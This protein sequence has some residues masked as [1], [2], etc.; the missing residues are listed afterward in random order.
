MKTI[1]VSLVVAGLLL[2]AIAGAQPEPDRPEKRPAA[3]DGAGPRGGGPKRPP[4]PE[5]T[6]DDREGPPGGPGG[7]E[8]GWKRAD[9]D[10]SGTLSREEFD[11]MPRIQ[12]LPVEKRDRIFAR[13]DKDGDKVLSAEELR[14][15][16]R[17]R[18]DGREAM[19][20]FR[21]LDTDHSGGVSLEEMKAGE[22]FKKLPPEK[23]AILFKRLDTDGDGEITEKDRPGP[24]MGP[25]GGERPDRP[26]RG[27][28]PPKDLRRLIRDFDEN[29]DGSLSFDEFRKAPQNKNLSEDEQEDRFEA[30]D[31][32]GD[33]KIDEQDF[34]PRPEGG[35]PAGPPPHDDGPPRDGAKPDPGPPPPAAPPAKPE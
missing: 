3:P 24:P 11:N 5:A 17:P 6:P 15:M 32:N 35:R 22:L 26:D 31:Q 10:G 29:G 21:E 20:R 8:R 27:E 13:L 34:P 4:G 2:P 19:M 9:T 30:L 1:P 33:K 12:K 23:L 18:P 28:R 7:F 16:N 25:D 14:V